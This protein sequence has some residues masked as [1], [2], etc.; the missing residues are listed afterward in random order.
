MPSINVNAP[1]TIRLTKGV[2]TFLGNITSLTQVVQFNIPEPVRDAQGFLI[3]QA[4]GTAGT[5]VT[6][7]GSVDQ[8]VTWFVMSSSATI[9]LNITGQLNGDPAAGAAD[10]FQVNGMGA[11]V[12]FRYGFAGGAPNCQVWACMG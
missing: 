4:S 7:E 3:I 2:A 10:A 8:G 5:T 12:L 6:L 9:V 11:G 1:L